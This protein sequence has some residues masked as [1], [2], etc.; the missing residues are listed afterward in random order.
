MVALSGMRNRWSEW[1]MEFVLLLGWG[2]RILRTH[3]ST[4]VHLENALITAGSFG[5]DPDYR[6]IQAPKHVLE[7]Q[8]PLAGLVHPFTKSAPPLS[9]T[10]DSMS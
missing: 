5:Q 9:R 7:T 10:D 8:L 1:V 3:R 2:S 6:L 4:P